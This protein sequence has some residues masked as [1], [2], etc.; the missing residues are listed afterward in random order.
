LNQR[1]APPA[2]VFRGA[3][4]VANWFYLAFIVTI[5]VLHVTNNAAIP[6]SM[7]SSKSYI[8]WSGVQDAMA[9]WWHGHN[10]G[11]LFPHNRLP[12]PDD[13]AGTQYGEKTAETK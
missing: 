12:R 1:R 10:A 6:I 2:V 9:E 3:L 13:V 5:A 8:V 7:F 11:R 4:H